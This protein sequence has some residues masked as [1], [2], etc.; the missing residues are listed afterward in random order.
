MSKYRIEWTDE[1]WYAVDVEAESEQDALDKF[2]NR[3]YDLGDADIIG[4]EMQNSITVEE[5]E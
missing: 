4:S 3:E 1:I 5:V 2:S